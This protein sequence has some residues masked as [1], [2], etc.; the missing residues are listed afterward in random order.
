MQLLRRHHTPG[1]VA[2]NVYILRVHHILHANHAGI[3]SNFVNTEQCNVRVLIY[4]ARCQ[5][6]ASAVNFDHIVCG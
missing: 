3:G 5:M 1:K 6:F 4:D 2:I